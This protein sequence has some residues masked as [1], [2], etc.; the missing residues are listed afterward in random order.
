MA[1]GRQIAAARALLG[2]SQDELADA[3]G[4]HVNSIAYWERH[5][6]IP[7]YR[8]PLACERIG[9][10]LREA[11]VETFLNPAPGVRF[12]E[13]T[14]RLRHKRRGQMDETAGAIL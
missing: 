14:A 7:T 9:D 8:A 3:S 5:A 4:L 12:A 6:A 13:P 2:W 10:A 1:T 11:G